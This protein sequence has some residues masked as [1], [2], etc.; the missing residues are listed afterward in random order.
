MGKKIPIAFLNLGCAS[1]N[2]VA[3][4]N[5]WKQQGDRERHLKKYIRVYCTI[6]KVFIDKRE[7]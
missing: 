7:N 3:S 6:V 1:R 2:A 5:N 4:F